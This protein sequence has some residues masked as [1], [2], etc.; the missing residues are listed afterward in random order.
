MHC[1]PHQTESEEVINNPQAQYNI[2]KTQN[3]PV[4]LPTFLQKNEGDPAIKVNRFMLITCLHA[5]TTTTEFF[6][7]AKKTFTPPHPG[8]ASAGSSI[9]PRAP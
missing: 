8:D 7:E 2:G 1:S 5:N 9:P 6:P 4:H 3:S